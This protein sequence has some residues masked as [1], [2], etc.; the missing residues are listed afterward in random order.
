M[1]NILGQGAF[2]T[3]YMAH[4]RGAQVRGAGTTVLQEQLCCCC[5]ARLCIKLSMAA[6]E[7][8]LANV[9]VAC[10]DA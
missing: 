7:K 1:G 10:T 6:S 3:T 8:P 5:A 2:G 4:W 9:M